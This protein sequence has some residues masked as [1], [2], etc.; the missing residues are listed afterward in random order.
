[1][2]KEF[3]VEYQNVRFP[4]SNPLSKGFAFVEGENK[5]EV[6]IRFSR[7]YPHLKQSYD[8]FFEFL[9]SKGVFD[10][11]TTCVM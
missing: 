8:E 3:F 5:R 7:K 4:N 9:D 6:W 2:K 1:M 10:R 11:S